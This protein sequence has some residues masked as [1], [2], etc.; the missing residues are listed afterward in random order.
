MI[1]LF[2]N[3]VIKP[4]QYA[5]IAIKACQATT[6]ITEVDGVDTIPRQVTH[7]SRQTEVGGDDFGAHFFQLGF[8]ALKIR[9]FFCA[10]TWH[11]NAHRPTG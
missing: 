7:R 9:H 10:H 8:N 4:I 2:F 11:Q 6:H 1:L 5:C 3:F